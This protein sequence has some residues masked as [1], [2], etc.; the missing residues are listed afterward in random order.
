[1]NFRIGQEVV[2]I[3]DHS[4]GVIKKGQTFIIKN[5][6]V[7]ECCGFVVADLGINRTGLGCKCKCGQA[8]DMFGTVHWISTEIL[9]PV[10]KS[11]GEQVLENIIKQIKEEELQLI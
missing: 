5:L 8:Y 2:C 9:A 4:Q 10:E 6:W 3:K 1:M 7:R 11:F